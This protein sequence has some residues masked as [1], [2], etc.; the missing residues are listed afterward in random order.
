MGGG[1]AGK[2]RASDPVELLQDLD[3]IWDPVPDGMRDAVRRA[4]ASNDALIRQGGRSAGTVG[5]A[6]RSCSKLLGDPSKMV[7]R[8]AAW[9]CASRTAGTEYPTNGLIAALESRED[10]ARWGAARVFSNISRRWRPSEFGA[11]R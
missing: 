5:P 10:R 8:T 4:A 2:A 7:Q 1:N 9:A 3:G 11:V 6:T